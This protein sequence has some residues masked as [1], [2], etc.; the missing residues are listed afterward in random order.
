[1]ISP[2]STQRGRDHGIPSYNTF[3]KFCGLPE[4][5]SFNSVPSAVRPEA[6]AKIASVYNTVDEIDLWVGGLAEEPTDGIV[7][8]TFACII[9]K[10]FKSL[11]DG[12]RFFYHHTG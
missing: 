6:W 2:L 11:M 10:Q 5:E 7:G 8:P 12:D 4:A 3:R 9:G 1:M